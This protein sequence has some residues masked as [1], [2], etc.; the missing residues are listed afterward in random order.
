[1]NQIASSAIAFAGL[2]HIFLAPQHFAHA[3]AHGSFFA[4]SGAA[5]IIWAILFLRKPTERMYYIGIMLAGGLIILW[6]VTRVLP[7]PFEHEVGAV[8]LGGIVCKL[9][10]LVG[11]FTLIALAAQGRIVGL[12]KRSFG[13]LFSEAIIVAFFVAFLT[14]IAGHE[15]EPLMPFLAGQEHEEQTQ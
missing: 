8:D 13:R 15:F 3:P 11:L 5:E 9:S 2:I 12:T 6:A 10:E 1:M 14:Y 7:A 4:V